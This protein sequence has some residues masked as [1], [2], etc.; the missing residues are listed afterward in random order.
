MIYIQTFQSECQPPDEVGPGKVGRR[1]IEKRY[2]S[3]F[4][5][6]LSGAMAT[7]LGMLVNST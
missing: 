7:V 3:I 2:S 4:L 6:S 5:D 1:A